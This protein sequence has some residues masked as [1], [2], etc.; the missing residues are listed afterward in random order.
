LGSGNGTE[1]Q[2]T[3]DIKDRVNAENTVGEGINFTVTP[4]FLSFLYQNKD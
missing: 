2:F 4:F 3:Q 1:S